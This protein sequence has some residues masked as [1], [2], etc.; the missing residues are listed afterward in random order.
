M[1]TSLSVHRLIACVACYVLVSG[2][3]FVYVPQHAYAQDEAPAAAE[4]EGAPSDDLGL[5]G[6]DAG[7]APSFDV[8]PSAPA[9]P[10]EEAPT[11]APMEGGLGLDQPLGTPSEA[12]PGT[13]LEP[14][15]SEAGE[16]RT[17][18]SKDDVRKRLDIPA[19]LYDEVLKDPFSY[20]GNIRYEDIYV[21]QKMYS[22]KQGRFFIT[23]MGGGGNFFSQFHTSLSNGFGAGYYFSDTLGWEVFH[24]LFTH[25]FTNNR[26]DVFLNTF[27]LFAGSLELRLNYALSSSLIFSPFYGKFAWFG[28]R[29]LHYDL[30]FIAGPAVTIYEEKT[31]GFGGVGGLGFRV[32]LNKWSSLGVEFR[33]YIY[34]ET[35]PNTI[36]VATGDDSASIVSRFFLFLNLTVYFP[37]FAFLDEV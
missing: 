9:F 27:N 20:L 3:T 2:G 32:F 29:V 24:G 18:P 1:R 7:Q 31:M 34:M 10:T 25:T 12:I 14:L 35:V 4:P 26:H 16:L 6:E 21:V 11:A 37:K 36:A 5:F 23:A 30:Y 17:P 22:R 8:L 15:P 28:R 19:D 33:D 13:A